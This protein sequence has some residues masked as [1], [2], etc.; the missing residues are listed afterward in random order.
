[1]DI[2]GIVG[3]H[4]NVGR[5]YVNL[6]SIVKFELFIPDIGGRVLL[7]RLGQDPIEFVGLNPLL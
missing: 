5:G 4:Y 2:P 1:M 7:Y 6:G 3:E